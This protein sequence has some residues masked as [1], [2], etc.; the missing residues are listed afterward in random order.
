MGKRRV[1]LEGS[2][3]QRASDG[4]WIGVVHFGY[5][6][7]GRPVR[8]YVSA[9]SQAEAVRGLK[10]LTRMRDAALRPPDAR[11]TVAQLLQDWHDEELATRVVRSTAD[12][13]R[14][15]LPAPPRAGP[16]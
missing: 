5:D 11:L 12:Y 9:K 8:R 16:R 3:F 7:E 4:L 10:A 13:Y 14:S 15:G 6:A 1:N 2:L